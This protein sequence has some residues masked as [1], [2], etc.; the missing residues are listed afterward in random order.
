MVWDRREIETVV[1]ERLARLFDGPVDVI[2]TAWLDVPADAYAD[3]AART[4]DL[5]ARI[6]RRDPM[7]VREIT[8]AVRVEADGIV[9]S[10]DTV[11]IAALLGVAHADKAPAQCTL[12]RDVR[13]TRTGRALRRVEDSGVTACAEPNAALVRLLAQAHR[14]WGIL[15]PEPI[16]ITRLAQ[17]EGM[18]AAYLT[19]VLRLALLSPAVTDAI[20]VGKQRTMINVRFL[21]LTDAIVGDWKRQAAFMLPTN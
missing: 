13:L 17:R 7:L 12:T 20:L 8:R 11:A 16:D 3:L 4:R 18:H 21:T 14:L 5:A 6:Q 15:R 19:R 2:A 1:I 9:I 10:C